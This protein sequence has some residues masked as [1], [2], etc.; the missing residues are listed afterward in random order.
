MHNK[1]IIFY[2]AVVDFIN[3]FFKVKNVGGCFS[4]CVFPGWRVS[5]LLHKKRLQIMLRRR[6]ALFLY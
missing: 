1:E 3:M 5:F 4:E 6:A 2:L